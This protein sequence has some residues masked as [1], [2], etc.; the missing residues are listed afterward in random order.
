MDAYYNEL[1]NFSLMDKP[2]ISINSHCGTLM[3]IYITAYV[4]IHIMKRLKASH[5]ALLLEK[6]QTEFAYVCCS[7]KLTQ[8]PRITA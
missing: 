6:Y 7:R 3:Y 4:C 8:Q 2:K 1:D 5:Q